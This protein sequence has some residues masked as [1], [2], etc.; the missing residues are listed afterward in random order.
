MDRREFLKLVAGAGISM[1]VPINML[2]SAGQYH[3]CA[4]CGRS[5]V[6]LYRPYGEFLRSERIRCCRHMPYDSKW[7]VPLVEDTDGS[8]WG[9]TS[10]PDDAIKRWQDLPD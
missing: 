10:V 5:A 3:K 9:Y 7:Y 8:V 2:G 4:V 1:F 6:R